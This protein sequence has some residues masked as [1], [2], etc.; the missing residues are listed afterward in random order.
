MSGALSTFIK[1]ASATLS[2]T[3]NDVTAVDAGVGFSSTVRTFQLPNTAVVGGSPPYTYLWEYVSGSMVIGAFGATTPNPIWEAEVTL[4]EIADWRLTVTDS[5]TTTATVE[6]T[7]TLV[8]VS[9][10]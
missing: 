7:I 4:Q 6:I 3:A 5:A 1:Q 8:W 9:F 10:S 2:V